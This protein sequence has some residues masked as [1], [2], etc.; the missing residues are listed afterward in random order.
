MAI[1]GRFKVA[2][3]FK[4]APACLNSCLGPP[5]MPP[6]HGSRPDLD[7]KYG[8]VVAANLSRLSNSDWTVPWVPNG[9]AAPQQNATRP[10]YLDANPANLKVRYCLA[11]SKDSIC[12]V[13]LMN[14]L[15]GITTLCIIL[16]M[17]LCLIVV[18]RLSNA[19]ADAPLVTP[20]DAIQ[21]F[22]ILPDPTTVDRST[23][24]AQSR[25]PRC[26]QC[27][28]RHP[29]H[30]MTFFCQTCKGEDPSLLSIDERLSDPG[31]REWTQSWRY[32]ASAVP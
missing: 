8:L 21:S 11:Q 27:Q 18:V 6:N 14:S 4:N 29:F 24:S 7:G 9:E 15:L 22:I 26:E 2:S 17:V 20:G 23:V 32:L 3:G 19:A 30:P 13:G 16:K 25:F 5:G 10:D 31:P 28:T 1:L 12:N